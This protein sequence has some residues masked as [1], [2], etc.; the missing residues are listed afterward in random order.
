MNQVTGGAQSQMLQKNMMVL[1]GHLQVTWRSPGTLLQEQELCQQGFVW[2]VKM[3]LGLSAIPQRNMAKAQ[4]VTMN[5]SL[6]YKEYKN[7]C[8]STMYW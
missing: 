2:V 8:N 5:F 7:V 3:V 4:V 6:E 1:L